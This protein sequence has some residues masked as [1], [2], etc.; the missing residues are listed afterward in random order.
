MKPQSVSF[1]VLVLALSTLAFPA[2]ADAARSMPAPV[3]HS[4]EGTI[5]AVDTESGAP[6]L[7]IQPVSNHPATI[8]LNK[9]ET[10]VWQGGKQLDWDTLKAGLKVKVRN[11]LKEGKV[12]AK[13]IEIIT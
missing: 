8:Y 5:T 12:I 1:V 6:S 10:A 13:S 9:S 2:W 11:S 4:V 3:V 7:T